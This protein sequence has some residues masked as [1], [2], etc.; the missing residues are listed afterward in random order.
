ME[1]GWTC[2]GGSPTFYDTCD[3]I[4]GDGIRFNS[5]ITYWDDGDTNNGDG[6]NNTCQ[7]EYEWICTGG[8]TTTQD[9]WSEIWGDGIRLNLISTYWDDGDNDSGDG[10]SIT[11]QV[12]H[13]W[14]CTGGSIITSD[15]WSEIWGDGIRFNN[16]AIYWDDN[17][18]SNG[19]GWS[20]TC[21]VE[22]GWY[23]TGG[24]I[25]TPDVWNE[26][27]GDGIRFNSNITY[28]DDKNT[29]S[30]DGCN[31]TCQVEHG[32]KC[33][34]GNSTMYDTWTEVCGDGIRFNYLNVYWDD[35]NITNGDGCSDIWAIER[36][37][38]W[39]GGSPNSSD[40]WNE[41]WSDGIRFS[42]NL[43]YCD[44][45]NL[46]NGD[47]CNSTWA[48]EYDYECSGGTSHSQDIWKEICG[49][50]IRV[51]TIP[52]YW[53]DYNLINGDGWSSVCAVE[54]GYTFLIK[55][56][57]KKFNIFWICFNNINILYQYTLIR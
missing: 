14:I 40:I 26:I 12:E 21:Q 15:V 11:C 13:G 20:S 28:W 39:S 48:I 31:S 51:N 27:W 43:T 24:S 53:D 7:I 45:G 34:G 4:C 50:G 3:E 56:K 38:S 5:N 32:W 1:V 47:G 2:S 23:W 9:I 42:T 25:T 17:N 19:D 6:C 37:W 41:I 30:G 55:I 49:D 16:N 35:G 46:V 22:L 33:T 18:T 57:N 44:D 52:T 36:G 10:C 54:H 29:M 8:S